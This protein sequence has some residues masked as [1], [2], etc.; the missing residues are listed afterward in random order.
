MGIVRDLRYKEMMADQRND[1]YEAR[2]A[3]TNEYNIEKEKQDLLARPHVLEN[4][5]A[6]MSNY[7]SPTGSTYKSKGESYGIDSVEASKNDDD[8]TKGLGYKLR[9]SFTQALMDP[10]LKGVP[11]GTILQGVTQ[12]IINTPDKSGISPLEQGYNYT[13]TENSRLWGG[14]QTKK[15]PGYDQWYADKRVQEAADNEK[16]SWFPD[17]KDLAT[18]TGIGA[19]IGAV[20][21][22]L[23]GG[24]AA[25]GTLAATGAAI[26]TAIAPGI[27]TVLGAGAGALTGALG[28]EAIGALGGALI[29][30]LGGA[31]GELIA[32]PFKK[33]VHKT[34]WYQGQQQSYSA[35]D[36]AKAMLTD[37][38][39][40]VV[41]D[42]AVTHLGT[43]YI[44][45]IAS[46]T[47]AIDEAGMKS[48][49]GRT[50]D[51]MPDDPTFG[52]FK[53]NLYPNYEPEINKLIGSDIKQPGPKVTESENL[54]GFVRSEAWGRQ[55]TPL[56]KKTYAPRTDIMNDIDE[57][58]AA[59]HRVN[60]E[61]SLKGGKT[62]P[63]PASTESSDLS[64]MGL[65][66]A[67]GRQSKSMLP[68]SEP[69]IPTPV[70]RTDIM[71]DVDESAAT[72]YKV[73]LE[74]SLKP[75][76]VQPGPSSTKSENI[77][78]LPRSQAWGRQQRELTDAIEN[79]SKVVAKVTENPT[80]KNI[81][82]NP[83]PKVEDTGGVNPLI[84]KSLKLSDDGLVE[85]GIESET[86]DSAAKGVKPLT[87]ST[88]DKII[89]AEENDNFVKLGK[90]DLDLQHKLAMKAQID[91]ARKTN[92]KS[93]ATEEEAI[94]A[95]L[96][97]VRQKRA[98]A[99]AEAKKGTTIGDMLDELDPSRKA[100]VD[101][102]MAPGE[103]KTIVS[104][105][106]KK[107]AQEAVA[108]MTE[109]PAER[110]K[111]SDGNLFT[112]KKTGEQVTR[113]SM[114]DAYFKRNTGAG[115]S[116]AEFIAGSKEAGMPDNVINTEV[117]KTKKA[118]SSWL[119]KQKS[120]KVVAGMTALGLGIDTL[121]EIISPS[122]ADAGLIDSFIKTS[123]KTAA[124]KAAIVAD[125][126]SKGYVAKAITKETV[127]GAENFQ[128]G[129]AHN[130][131]KTLGDIASSIRK[132]AGSGVQYSLMSPYQAIESIMKTGKDLMVN[133]AP[134]LASYVSAGAN[135]IRNSSRVF[136]NIMDEAG[137]PIAANQVRKAMEPLLE[138][139]AKATKADVIKAQLGINRE[140]LTNMMAKTDI[141]DQVA[142]DMDIKKLSDTIVE[143]SDKYELVKNAPKEYHNLVN[144]TY[145]KLAAE[146]S[147]VRVALALEDPKRQLYP[148]LNLNRNEEIAV[149]K[150][151]GLLDQYKIRLA[152]RGI[153]VRDN[154]FP[155]SPHPEMA[156]IF[157]A[158]MDDI[159]GGIPYN[160]FYSRTESSRMLMPDAHYS[161]NHYLN[162]I[163]QRIQH[164]DFWKR[165]GWEK[166]M[167]SDVIQ[168]NPGLKKAFE[169]LYEGTKPQ[170]NS[171]G[172]I[173]A[174]RYAEIEAVKRLFLNPSA[175][176]KHLV[177]LTGDV[178]S[179]GLAPV[180]KSSPEMSGYVARTIANNIYDITPTV[181]KKNLGKLGIRNE[182]FAKTL[183]D[184]YTD[185]IIQTGNIRKYM[186]DMGME[187]QD[188][189]FNGLKANAKNLWKGVQD[190]GSAWINLA[191]L[192]D[193]S[194]SVNS[195]LQMSAKRGMT[196]DQALY[197]TYDLILKNNFLYGQFNPSWLNNPKIRAAFMFQATP[198]KIFERRLVNAQRSGSNIKDL[199]SAVQKVW[200]EPGGKEKVINDVR[201]LRKYIREGESELKAN[202]IADT[203]RQETDYFGTP[204]T[205]QFMRD[206]LTVGAF[207]YGGANIGLHLKDHF[208]HIPFLSTM[209]S[210]G[211]AELAL[212]PAISKT[213]EGY[214]AWKKREDN[215]DFL[216]TTVLRKW[217]GPAGPMPDTFHKAMRLTQ[218]DIPE[219]YRQGGGNAYL[220][221]LFGIPGKE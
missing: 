143:L 216:L 209:S 24:A 42:S 92:S 195:A 51:S 13:R 107:E 108:S 129:I 221:Y 190:V 62:Q 200:K 25:A 29:G 198:F 181:I 148:W 206:L 116:E 169:N 193:R 100:A 48:L 47:Q 177:K 171:W 203:L 113:D 70:P 26:G 77:I 44:K 18:T 87:G 199:H 166:V 215:D 96:E 56:L 145:Q 218:D 110:L 144:E 126:F 10:R 33:L 84:D 156:K 159:L 214:N 185:S 163:E 104:K 31:A 91:L 167:R 27:G 2:K 135:N 28:G 141:K 66:E 168:A 63:G 125:A 73:N 151:R 9:D 105:K 204:V 94:K 5:V 127:M 162:D 72:V 197:G 155:H 149:G 7:Y 61:E 123:S 15:I 80:A 205:Q 8:P 11:T 90:A 188:E 130:A 85:A 46:G 50:K 217:A 40:Y 173:A 71:S 65:S 161:M 41:G 122:S 19:G 179:V 184:N 76:N 112:N 192:M 68:K 139:A 109:D 69:D 152:S 187:S 60:L 12:N 118:F 4:A 189:F 133:A 176:V 212:S 115:L 157:N 207:T 98:A 180:L 106:T 32:T 154:Y 103:V 137:I 37:F 93:T 58:G 74:E 160:K 131:T 201:N 57:S 117:E 36:R 45:G 82:D 172:N 20:T 121:S 95:T 43:N 147:S 81:V 17:L 88:G 174:N 119:T 34:D 75:G 186:M 21:G 102:D 3:M 150:V 194:V 158:E 178:M 67:W 120:F 140:N 59:V 89:K 14:V 39:P 114:Y 138:P 191:E 22:G 52:Q 79:K 211:K 142:H 101:P 210:E 1:E 196:V 97:R 208:F 165:S 16:E 153:D 146:H 182:R 83:V 64:R 35:V 49:F 6:N 38:V 136:K 55:G 202:L 220:K 164:K 170:E 213:M 111:A 54:G 128:R 175:G 53:S 99:E 134:Y 86:K 132:G 124:Q 219:I 23:G 30:G 183:M 78:A